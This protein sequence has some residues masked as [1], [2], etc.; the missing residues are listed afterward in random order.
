MW[1]AD[2]V[3]FSRDLSRDDTT[4]GAMTIENRGPD[5]EGIWSARP[6]TDT[7]PETINHIREPLD[8]EQHLRLDIEIIQQS[9]RVWPSGVYVR[10]MAGVAG[11]PAA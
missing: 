1:I 7:L 5:A 3:D 6:H 8:V 9:R 11:A 4:I 10:P 2:W